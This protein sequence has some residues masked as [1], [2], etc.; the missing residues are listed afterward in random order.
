M[1]PATSGIHVST[2]IEL[3]TVCSAAVPRYAPPAIAVPHRPTVYREVD[4]AEELANSITHGLG[5]VLSLAGLY[6]LVRISAQGGNPA[7]IAGC[8]T[9][10]VAL[11]LL[12]TAS[13]LCHACWNAGLKRVLLVCDHI[14]IYLL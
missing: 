8:V 11:V 6:A 4:R 14:G 7:Q 1:E 12:Y 9:Y 10:G 2:S 13:T 3:Y 5:A